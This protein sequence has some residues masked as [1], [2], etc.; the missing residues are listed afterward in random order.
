LGSIPITKSKQ[1]PQKALPRNKVHLV[2]VSFFTRKIAL[3]DYLP[4]HLNIH[5]Y[6][7]VSICNVYVYV[8]IDTYMH[9]MNR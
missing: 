6:V 9:S 2:Y 5:K 4:F 1:T 3:I 8:S 7:H